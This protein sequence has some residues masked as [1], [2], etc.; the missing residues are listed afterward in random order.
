MVTK[1]DNLKQAIL[2]CKG[3]E[4]TSLLAVSKTLSM[5][6]SIAAAVGAA[7]PQIVQRP[8]SGAGEFGSRTART[9]GLR[10]L[11]VATVN[12]VFPVRILKF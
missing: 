5:L 10:H 4:G 9:K 2:S 1:E 11:L 8:N 3:I 12:R 7:S 6:R